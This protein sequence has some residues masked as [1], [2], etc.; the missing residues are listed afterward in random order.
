MAKTETKASAINKSFKKGFYVLQVTKA[1]VKKDKE[2]YDGSKQDEALFGLVVCDDTG[3]PIINPDDPDN[4]P[5]SLLL[6]GAR[7]PKNEYLISESFFSDKSETNGFKV[8]K[9]AG[10]EPSEDLVFDDVDWAAM[11][12]MFLFGPV[13]KAKDKETGKEKDNLTTQIRDLEPLDNQELVKQNL[14]RRSKVILK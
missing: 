7:R 4:K 5:Y 8:L 3:K 11:E 12:G 14:A 2:Q 1:G 9:N 6:F 13:S 10:L